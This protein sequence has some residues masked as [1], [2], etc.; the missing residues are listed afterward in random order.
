[1]K[2]INDQINPEFVIQAKKLAQ[3][4]R[5]LHRILPPECHGHVEVANIRDQNL[6]LITDSPVWTTK[7]RQLSPQILQF[8]QS[9]TAGDA[10]KSPV[11]HHVQ[12]STRYHAPDSSRQQALNKKDLHKLQI[13]EKTATMLAQSADSIEHE[14]LR[15]ALL[16]LASHANKQ[17]KPE[18]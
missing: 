2:S 8:L 1:M 9:N 17:N 5:L 7:L 3:F 10:S 13:S 6:M 12:I 4:S 16:K 14:P 15:S 11:I 18:K